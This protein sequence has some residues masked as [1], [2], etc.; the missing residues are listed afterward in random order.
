MTLLKNEFPELADGKHWDADKLDRKKAADYLT[1]LVASIAQPFVISLASDYGTGKTFFIKCWQKDL[2]AAEFKTV[3]FNAWETDFSQD[4]LFAVISAMKRELSDM[5]GADTKFTEAAKKAAALAVRKF[6]PTVVRATSR[7]V[8]GD[9]T[10]KEIQDEVSK[11]LGDFA[12]DRLKAQESA[13]KSLFEFKAYLGRIVAELTQDQTDV[14]KQKIIVFVDDLDRCR[15]D[16][17]VSV[18][19]CIKHLFSVQGLVFVLSIDDKQLHQAVASVYGPNIDADGYLR[20]FIDWRFRLPT[21]S[22]IAFT[23]FLV[24]KYKI[25]DLQQFQTRSDFGD[26]EMLAL[27]IGIF[28]SAFGFSLRRIEQCFVEVNLAIRTTIAGY[29]PYAPIL[30]VAS[31][32]R[33]RYPNE[34]RDCI[35]GKMDAIDFLY[36]VEPA[37][38]NQNFFEFYGDWSQMRGILYSWF[39][40]SVRVGELEKNLNKTAGSASALLMS[41]DVNRYSEVDE[42]ALSIQAIEFWK[43]NNVQVRLFPKSLMHMCYDRLEGTPLLFPQ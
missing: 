28:S 23:R 40:T 8:L 33:N 32:F 10:T 9:E 26:P 27:S 17:A 29:I 42:T 37:L 12:E 5:V 38:K 41:T 36:L 20:R 2:E 22:T 6:L 19:E 39:L 43:S 18:L 14:Q 35:S 34:L 16:Y 1:P 7:V 21:P 4:A 3:Y 25:G 31:V 13:E 30:G 11:A 24:E 15:P